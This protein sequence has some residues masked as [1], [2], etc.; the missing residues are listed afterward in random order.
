MGRSIVKAD[1]RR[2]K[3]LNDEGEGMIEA[4]IPMQPI[5]SRIV[6][7][8]GNVDEN[9]IANVTLQ[10]LYLANINH[11]PITFVVSTYGGSIDEMFSLYDTM[12]FLPC[13]VHTVA[14]GKVMSA[15]VLLLAA[16]EKGKRL[17]GS[18]TRIM[19]HPIMAGVA[20][21][22]F[23]IVNSSNEIKRQHDLFIKSIVK[24]T[25]MTA[26]EVEN[27]MA[28]GHDYYVSAEQAIKMGIVDQII[29]AYSN[30]KA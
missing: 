30:V 5:E 1:S 21:N 13:P 20:G 27:V 23:E 15:G 4:V 24:E 8:H 22:V 6:M 17:I 7:L 14:L 12:K 18:T 9:A 26:K 3:H 19:M 11:E 28:I 25:K 29:G 2:L 16:G 10:L